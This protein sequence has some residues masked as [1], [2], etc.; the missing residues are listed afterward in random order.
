M[1]NVLKTW[2]ILCL[3]VGAGLMD[4]RTSH[5]H[6]LNPAGLTPFLVDGEMVGAATN[7][8]LVLYVD[9]TPTWWSEL[10]VHGTMH[11]YGYTE[12]GRI[13]VGTSNTLL[14]TEDGG[15]SFEGH[16]EAFGGVDV[17]SMATDPATAR[18]HFIATATEDAPNGIYKTPDGGDTW[19][20]VP[21]T[22]IDGQYL[23]LRYVSIDGTYLALSTTETPGR[24][25]FSV[26]SAAGQILQTAT[27]DIEVSDIVRLITPGAQAGIGF[28][29]SFTRDLDAEPVPLGTA[30][31]G[32]DN[33]YRVDFINGTL[34]LVDS[35]NE[36]NRFFSGAIF[37]GET[38]VTDYDDRFLLF[39]EGG[40]VEVGEEVRYCIDDSLSLDTYWACGRRPQDYTFFNSTDAETWEG[41]LLFDDITVGECP[42]KTPDEP[43]EPGDG[44]DLSGCGNGNG[45]STSGNGDSSSDGGDISKGD[46][47]DTQ[48][49]SQ[50][51]GDSEKPIADSGCSA[52]SQGLG[53]LLGLVWCC[54][55]FSVHRRRRV[56]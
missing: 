16:S 23:S 2:T 24:F 50:L 7:L 37:M 19:N 11:W 34:D 18:P 35:L 48:E 41:V 53:W 20:L 9:G 28:V 8:G 51:G 52:A 17:R 29:A 13:L 10:R 54:G 40:L 27:T 46:L 47:P 26:L 45:D 5:A 25:Q 30:L 3:L 32:T 56:Y 6:G 43:G 14:V 12:S 22:E 15:C 36:S 49:P 4:G 39:S 42:E 21:E 31:P 38:Y 55:R 44:V 33:L 1:I